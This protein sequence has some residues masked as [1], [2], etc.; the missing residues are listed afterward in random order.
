MLNLCYFTEGLPRGFIWLLCLVDLKTIWRN[1]V[2]SLLP[3]VVSGGSQTSPL[4]TGEHNTEQKKS[5]K[6]YYTVS[7]ASYVN[8]NLF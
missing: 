2:T 6:N 5:E 3:P 8:S 7:N 1:T 4:I